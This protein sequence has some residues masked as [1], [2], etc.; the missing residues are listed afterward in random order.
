ML[1]IGYWLLNPM[2]TDLDKLQ[3]TWTVSALEVDGTPVPA[4]SYPNARI[5][6]EGDRFT[7]L[8]MGLAYDGTMRV[9]EKKKPKAFDIVIAGG[10]AAGTRSLGIYKLAGDRWTICLATRGTE[11]PTTFATSPGTGLALE[12]LVRG[13]RTP[14]KSQRSSKT[15]R[16]APGAPVPTNTESIGPA[17]DLEGEWAM[18]SAVFNGVPMADDMVRW[19]KRVTRGDITTVLAGP[20]TMLRAR[21]TLDDTTTPRGVEYMNLEGSNA[22]KSQ[23]G[24]VDLSGDTLKICMSPPGKPRPADFSSTRGDGRSYTTWRRSAK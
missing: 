22:R 18:V 3:G 4:S 1:A 16:H 17:T 21:F 20:Q 12:S 23:S 6:I 15:G 14:A 5:V 8:D 7:S 9:D 2:P 13:A 11:R 10:H 24:I 19:C